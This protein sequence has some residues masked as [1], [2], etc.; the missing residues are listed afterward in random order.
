MRS[1]AVGFSALGVLSLKGS[2]GYGTICMAA[3]QAPRTEAVMQGTM[4][5]TLTKAR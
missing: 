4:E 2:V 1:I 3:S 5:P